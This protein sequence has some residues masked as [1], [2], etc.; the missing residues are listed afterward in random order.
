MKKQIDV[1]ALLIPIS[2][3][4]PSGEDLRYTDVYE[5]I[6]E[7]RRF[8]DP[9]DQ[10]DWKTE[11]KTAD[12]E[13]AI[14]LCVKALSERTKDLQI[15]AWLT[16]AMVVTEGF[17]GLAVG[18]N[19][20]SGLLEKFWDTLYPEIEEGDLDYRVAPLE[21]LNEK[22]WT[23]VK[24]VPI[25]DPGK[26]PG[27]SWLKWQESRETGSEADTRDKFGETDE[28]KKRRRDE[29]IQ[30]G[31]LTGE[32]FDSAMNATS[33]AFY[34]S[35]SGGLGACLEAFRRLDALVDEKFGNNAPRLAE[36]GKAIEDC[37]QVVQRICKERGVL[38]SPEETKA[39][40]DSEPF[41]GIPGGFKEEPEETKAELREE[42]QPVPVES[43]EAPR[44]AA[45]RTST[46][47]VRVSSDQPS[48]L[49]D[50][51]PWEQFLWEEAVR[52]TAGPGVKKAL[53]RLL[54]A[55]LNAPSVRERNRLKLL[56]AKL[57]LK[58]GRTD[59]ARPIL[60]QLN[61]VVDQFQLEQWES[62]V[63][64]GEVL[65]SLYQCLMSGEPSDDDYNRAFS[66]FQKL[67]T[68]DITKA[69]TY[70]KE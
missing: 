58:A 42:P 45:Q 1:E 2:D 57:C 59:L 49:T 17:S 27:Y 14:S 18:L 40:E 34:T 25:T 60:E 43:V 38:A 33:P 3:D 51:S 47:P 48:P 35:L 63:W 8:D 66:L 23:M 36:L 13:K 41:E 5:Q 62:P 67:C 46:A 64:I 29:L 56:E 32:E 19:T 68:I 7:A 70:R 26:T 6:K 53:E 61:T 9:L 44:Q 69:L 10:G 55:T 52:L 12:W 50:A 24:Q 54:E 20:I 15:A 37:T 21:F 31:R 30:E 16:E 65:G 28:S 11:R 22:L 4:L 39:P